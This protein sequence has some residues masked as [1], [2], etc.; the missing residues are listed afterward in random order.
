[1]YERD[2]VHENNV[3]DGGPRSRKIL[4]YGYCEPVLFLRGREL[5]HENV[6]IP[7]HVLGPRGEG[8]SI[9]DWH[10][11]KNINSLNWKSFLTLQDH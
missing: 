7:M 10:G 1:M 4:C 11:F 3:R 5:A 9:I 8:E 2:A 6:F